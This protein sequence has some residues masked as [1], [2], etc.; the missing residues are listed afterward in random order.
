M[1][2]VFEIL[3]YILPSLVMLILTYLL[4]KLF[5]EGDL[6][7]KMLEIRSARKDIATPLRLQAYERMALF[8][9]RIRLTGLVM[10][11]NKPGYSADQMRNALL[12]SIREEFDHNLSQQI[13]I[14]SQAWE[15]IKNAKESAIKQV[16][17]EAANL[18]DASSGND[19]ATAIL[20]RSMN[21]DKNPVDQALGFLKQEARELF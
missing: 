19:L 12:S 17:T 1:N 6:R 20:E 5:L 18:S 10:R 14:S 13:Y 4:I 15:R 2:E 21:K 9:E 7:K 3:K 8:L 11:I 16:N